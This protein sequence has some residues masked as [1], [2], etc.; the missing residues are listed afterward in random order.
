[1]EIQTILFD[2]DGTLLPMDQEQFIEYYFG[3][4]GKYMEPYGYRIE[5]LSRVIWKGTEAMVRNQS[6]QKN[7]KVFWKTVSDL[8][9]KKILQDIPKFEDFY[10]TDFQKIAAVCPPDPNAPQVIQKLKKDG[11]RLILATNPIFPQIAT[12]SR[13]SWGR[14]NPEDFEL[15]TTYENSSRTKPNPEYYLEILRKQNLNPSECLMVGND[16]TEDGAAARAGLP[17]FILTNHLINRENKDLSGYPH[18]G[19][20]E[21]L[22]Y[23]KLNG[24]P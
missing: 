7:E 14:L 11:Y 18:G 3:G 20:K 23:L 22:E 15:I 19:F 16:V 1:M 9:G 17:V 12:Y 4:L 21:L 24:R 2:L 5:D 8:Y 6:P 10:R 13:I